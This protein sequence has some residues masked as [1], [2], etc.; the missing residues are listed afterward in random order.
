MEL[1][2]RE[3]ELMARLISAGVLAGILC[4]ATMP[5]QGAANGE[6]IPDLSSAD[7]AWVKIG[8]DFVAPPSGPSPVTFDNA[9]PY[10]PNND[11]GLQPTYRVADTTQIRVVERYKLTEGGKTL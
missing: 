2:H 5:A 8:D 9:H 1:S 10:Q 7:L 6:G 11:R 3:G 4:A